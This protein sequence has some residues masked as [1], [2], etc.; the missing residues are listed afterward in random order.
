MDHLQRLHS[1]PKNLKQRRRRSSFCVSLI[2]AV[3]PLFLLIILRNPMKS[4]CVDA[5]FGTW[6]KKCRHT[7][8]T[9]YLFRRLLIVL[10]ESL[11]KNSLSACGVRTESV[12]Q[13]AFQKQIGTTLGK[14]CSMNSL[15]ADVPQAF[16]L[17]GLSLLNIHGTT[18]AITTISL[19]FLKVPTICPIQKLAA[20]SNLLFLMH[21]IRGHLTLGKE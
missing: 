20:S 10:L 17:W 8:N 5:E 19:H 3:K 16:P 13:T 1:G 2:A 4:S 7:A 11:K 18:L 12:M 6:Q 14:P 21:A 9:P 15:T